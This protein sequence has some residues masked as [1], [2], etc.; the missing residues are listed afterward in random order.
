LE[1]CGGGNKSADLT[2]VTTAVKNQIAVYDAIR[3]AN[4]AKTLKSIEK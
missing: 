2:G 1:L 3:K 4:Y